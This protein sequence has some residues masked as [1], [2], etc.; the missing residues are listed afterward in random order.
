MAAPD[1][2]GESE[3]GSP[4]EAGAEGC[5]DDGGSGWGGVCGVPL[6]GGDEERGRRGVAV[7]LDVAEEAG[8]EIGD[9]E[10]GGDFADEIHVGLV[11]EEDGNVSGLEIVFGQ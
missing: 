8:F 1:S 10:G 9:L 6:G 7:A 2:G 3:D 11:H 4:V 5:E